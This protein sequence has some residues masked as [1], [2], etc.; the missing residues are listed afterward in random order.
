MKV[1][2]TQSGLVSVSL[3]SGQES[4]AKFVNQSGDEAK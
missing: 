2:V 4:G 1:H 3:M